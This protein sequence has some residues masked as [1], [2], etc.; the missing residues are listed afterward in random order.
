LLNVPV[1]V[2]ASANVCVQLVLVPEQAPPLQRIHH[3]PPDDVIVPDVL[4][5][6]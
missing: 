6:K 4:Y 5:G 3:C 1:T 2:A